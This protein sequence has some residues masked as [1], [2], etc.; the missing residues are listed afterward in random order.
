MADKDREKWDSKYR[1]KP[2]G[3]EP[4]PVLKRFW[5]LASCAKALDIACGNGR[6]SL[7][8]AKQGFA[9]DAVDISRIA[10]GHLA[11]KDPMINVICED[12]DTWQIP[13]DR[14]TLIANIRFLDRRLFPMIQE[15]LQPGGVLIFESFMG[16]EKDAYCLEENELLRVFLSFRIVYYEEKK[17]KHSDRFDRTV[18][19]VAVKPLI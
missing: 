10:T 9:V 8:L 15:G 19:M 12:M 13:P 3:Y 17:S 2:G 1:R 6:N 14:Y 5:S 4:S 11:G 16:A 7:F 18:S